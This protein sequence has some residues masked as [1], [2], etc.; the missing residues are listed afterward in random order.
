LGALF[1]PVILYIVLFLSGSASTGGAV[2]SFSIS[3][4][5]ALIF[6]YKIPSLALIWYLLIKGGSVKWSAA[7]P[8]MGDLFSAA[9]A[10]PGLAL[11]GF[12]IALVSPHF[13]GIPQGPQIAPPSGFLPWLLLSFSCLSTGYLEESFFRFYLFSKRQE[14]GLSPSKAALISTFLFSLC[15][16]YEGPWGFL[17]AAISGILLAFVFLRYRSIHGIALAHGLYNIFAYAMSAF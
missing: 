8:G 3:G 16:I 4:E 17:N 12:T 7:R 13:S 2:I 9:W 6:L 5:L 10:F 15:H 1:E 11:T 14:M